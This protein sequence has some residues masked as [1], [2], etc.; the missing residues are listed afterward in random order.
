MLRSKCPQASLNRRGLSLGNRDVSWNHS[1]GRRGVQVSQGRG[2]REATRN[3]GNSLY[4]CLSVCVSPSPLAQ[5]PLFL[6]H[7][8]QHSCHQMAPA[9]PESTVILEFLILCNRQ[10]FPKEVKRYTKN[11]SRGSWLSE[12]V[13]YC[14]SLF[15]SL[16]SG[17]Q[18]D[19][20]GKSD[21]ISPLAV[22]LAC[23]EEGRSPHG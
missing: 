16:D 6:L 9:V 20:D 15:P 18:R 5:L 14:F 17:E 23:L 3:Q 4:F 1:A 22:G 19:R 12:N 2:K 11:K 13:F 21:A 7:M 10:F 8:A